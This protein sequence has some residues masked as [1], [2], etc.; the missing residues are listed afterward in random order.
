MR[1][2]TVSLR[3]ATLAIAAA[4][5]FSPAAGAEAVKI[6]E[7]SKAGYVCKEVGE[8]RHLCTRDKTDPTYGCDQWECKPIGLTAGGP[9]L[10]APAS[11]LLHGKG[12]IVEPG[13]PAGGFDRPP[14]GG[15]I[16]PR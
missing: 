1:K 12:A 2:R 9:N 16:A 10:R 6:G 11:G 3:L 14:A 13:S 7:L 4:T 5:L 8:A 15:I